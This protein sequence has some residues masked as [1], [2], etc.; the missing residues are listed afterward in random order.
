MAKISA[1]RLTAG[2]CYVSLASRRLASAKPANA[3]NAILPKPHNQWFVALI[4]CTKDKSKKKAERLLDKQVFG[5]YLGRSSKEAWT[6]P[7]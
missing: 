5:R 1:R 4:P 7:R 6:R 2:H 3:L